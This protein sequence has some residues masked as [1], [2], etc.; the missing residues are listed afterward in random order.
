MVLQPYLI[1]TE[2]PM[3][4]VQ[5]LLPKNIDGILVGEITNP[6]MITRVLMKYLNV[7]YHSYYSVNEV[8]FAVLFL[9]FR[10]YLSMHC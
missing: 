2:P 3:L 8:I 6:F 9:I 7:S 10:Y 4:L 5:N 1:D